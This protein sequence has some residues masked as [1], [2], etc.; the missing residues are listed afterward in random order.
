MGRDRRRDPARTGR[1]VPSLTAFLDTNVLIRHLTD[2]PP[3]AAERATRLLEAGEPLILTDVIVAECVH[4]LESYYE[5][6]P[7]EVT[8]LIRSAFDLPCVRT[9]D[10]RS[11]LR[12]L[13]IHAVTGID[14]PEA[15]LVSLAEHTG[16][17]QIVSFDRAI[18]R[19][20]SVNRRE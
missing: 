19:V 15:Y 7:D 12:A 3:E 2:D 11:L 5:L 14:F 8:R 4:V 20:P 1:E 10:P 17:E 9:L 16:V 13:E 18:D 6:D